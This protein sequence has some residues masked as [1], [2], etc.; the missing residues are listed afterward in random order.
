MTHIPTPAEMTEADREAVAKMVA[1]ADN[2]AAV[3]LTFVG[4]PDVGAYK[5]LAGLVAFGRGSGL[6]VPS[7][8]HLAAL[9]RLPPAADMAAWAASEARAAAIRGAA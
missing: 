9:E 8:R 7:S 5:A 4:A 6:F 3:I 1:Q 2:M